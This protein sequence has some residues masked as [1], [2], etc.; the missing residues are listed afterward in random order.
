MKS[1]FT[2]VIFMRLA[3]IFSSPVIFHKDSVQNIILIELKVQ[4]FV[5]KINVVLKIWRYLKIKQLIINTSSEDYL[6][7]SRNIPAELVMLTVTSPH[8]KTSNRPSSGYQSGRERIT[9][10]IL[11]NEVEPVFDDLL[12][13]DNCIEHRS[14]AATTPTL[15]NNNKPIE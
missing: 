1:R 3:R 7:H 2:R 4:P 11:L 15:K 14:R 10:T 9:I 8:V 12:C 13:S 6:R 5:R